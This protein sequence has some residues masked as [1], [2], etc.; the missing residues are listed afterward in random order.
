[1][2]DRVYEDHGGD[3]PSAQH[4]IADRHLAGGQAR[5]HAVVDALVATA[6]DDE[7]RLGYE[8]CGES[9][10]ERLAPWFH[11]HHGPGI[12]RTYRLD[13]FENGLGLDHHAWASTERQVVH[14]PVAVVCV[15]A[16]VVG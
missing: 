1:P 2:R 4:I 5:A 7:P 11:E 16:K 8:L 6:H 13:R 14:L 12:V 3:L 9:L 10:V 15:V